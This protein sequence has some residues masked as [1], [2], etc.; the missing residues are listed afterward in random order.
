MLKKSISITTLIENTVTQE[1]F[2]GEHGLSM[3]IETEHGNILWDT[4]QSG[5]LIE[6]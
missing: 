5:L 3:W 6:N 1:F 4:G 2:K